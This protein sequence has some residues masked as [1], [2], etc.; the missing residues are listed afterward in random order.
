[1]DSILC[2]LPFVLT[3]IDDIL[4]HS[5][6]EE[7]HKE[8]LLQVF[9]RLQ[10]AGLTL[11]GK[12]CHIGIPQVYYLGNMFS[13]AGMQPDHG[14]IQAVQEWP[15]PQNVTALKQFLGL[16]SYYRRYVENF[17][18]IAAP[19]HVLTQK[20]V[21][22]HWNQACDTAFSMLKGKLL[23]FPVLTYPNFAADAGPFVLQTDASA[24]GVGAVL[25]QDGHVIAYFSRALTKSEKQYSV[26]QQECLAAVAA[27]KQF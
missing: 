21:P 27:M 22:F 3:Y 6:T 20:N 5:A 7:L 12:K 19:L 14:N 24:V 11:R 18:T 9:A 1:M 25:E 10:E 8:H 16:A 4:I 26:I 17:A 13:G 15:L 23:E 2:G